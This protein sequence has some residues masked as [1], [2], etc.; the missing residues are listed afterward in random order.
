[1]ILSNLITLST[2]SMNSTLSRNT[3]GTYRSYYFNTGNN[4]TTVNFSAYNNNNNQSNYANI[5][6]LGIVLSSDTSV[7]TVDDY[8]FTNF[9]TS[10]D[11]TSVDSSFHSQPMQTVLTQTVRN[12]D[13]ENIV[14]NS[15]GAFGQLATN[16]EI[17]LLT[18][19]LLDT[20]VT[21]APG[22]V[23]TITVTIDYNSFV[24]NVNA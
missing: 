1:M 5:T 16:K 19:T 10:D 23:K 24:E 2:Y 9:Y 20:P 6:S 3:A 14:I 15:V 4:I 13:T 12:D 7:P 8:Q 18:K 11:L 22:E 21:V 17:M